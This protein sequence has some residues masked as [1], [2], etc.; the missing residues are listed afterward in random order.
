MNLD[1]SSYM[2]F[3][4]DIFVILFRAFR[5]FNFKADEDFD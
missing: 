5:D 1:K 3:E 2:E 4:S